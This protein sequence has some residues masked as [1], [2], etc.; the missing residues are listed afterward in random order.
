MYLEN[1]ITE[2]GLEG[3]DASTYHYWLW[4]DIYKRGSVPGPNQNNI[5]WSQV[6]E[7]LQVAVNAGSVGY[8]HIV[9]DEA[10]DIP[11]EL[12]EILNL[13]SKHLTV[14]MDERQG[15]NYRVDT[16]VEDVVNLICDSPRS[17]FFLSDNHRNSQAIIDLS[18][19]FGEEGEL[20]EKSMNPGGR[21]P[22]LELCDN[23][24]DYIK[25]ISEYRKDNPDQVIGVL[26]PNSPMRD[27]FYSK[28]KKDGVKVEKYLS[29]DERRSLNQS[30]DFHLDTKGLKLINVGVSKGLEFDTVFIP[31]IDDDYWT[32][33]SRTRVNQALVAI[34]RARSRL[35]FQCGM[36]YQG[37]GSIIL[38]RMLSH[39][40]LFEVVSL[41]NKNVSATSQQIVDSEDDDAFDDDIPF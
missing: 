2:V 24:G 4:K 32:E 22:V 35:F 9:L 16:K 13:I 28:F 37:S 26:L 17:K 38:N 27:D 20:P 8:D 6:K 5:D 41:G 12:I 34:T 33:E 40:E 39:P 15:I 7:D 29:S 18:V 25:S 19:K 30:S 31:G 23:T 21:K 36:N 1:A 3:A 14:F 10:Q 11:I